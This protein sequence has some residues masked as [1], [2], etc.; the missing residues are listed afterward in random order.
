MS[1]TT[2]TRETARLLLQTVSRAFYGASQTI[3]VDQL[4]RKEAMRDD[5]LA[6]RVGMPPKD[7][8]KSC[9]K[10]IEDGLVSVYRRPEL[11]EGAMKVTSRAYYY[12]DYSRA[13][14][15]V[16]WRMWKIR[17]E[18]DGKLRD[19]LK[20]QGYVCPLCHTNYTPLD[21]GSLLD[22]FRGGFFCI[23]CDTELVDNENEEQVQGNKDRMKRF[24]AETE[25]V[26]GLLKRIDEGILPRFD[27]AQYLDINVPNGVSTTIQ[28]DGTRIAVNAQGVRIE[29]AGD[30]D[31]RM[32][33]ERRERERGE[34]RA[35]NQLPSWIA[36]STISGEKTGEQLKREASALAAQSQ[37]GFGE[38]KPTT[39]VL[40]EKDREVD[41]DAYYASLEGTGEVDGE[42]EG[43]GIYSPATFGFG[44][45]DVKDDDEVVGSDEEHELISRAA[46][47]G[48]TQ[49]PLLENGF[50]EVGSG[51]KRSRED[52]WDA[53]GGADGGVGA[54]EASKK[55]KVS[56]SISP[57]A[58]PNVLEGIA[59]EPPV[60]DLVEEFDDDAFDEEELDG[61]PDPLINI[62]DREVRFSEITEAMQEEMSPEEYT[63]Y[64][65]VYARV[66]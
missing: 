21:A 43:D 23:K 51:G 20:N 49:K 33:E 16:K 24:L 63:V 58:S 3:V 57:V 1:K 15:V 52:S 7:V 17:E 2:D 65:D 14:D 27:V 35:Q 42:G 30:E 26:R 66:G 59:T 8:A 28:E 9:L 38:Q 19:E 54:E 56:L 50:G 36:Q 34:K 10:L 39:E 6:R 61:D 25:G 62:G 47:Q 40:E 37:A 44:F 55:Q 46:M 31:E 5:E 29:L 48:E 41:L 45:G 4:I 53:S 22:P 18:I 12:L 60:D 13:T 64:W 11:R 32:E